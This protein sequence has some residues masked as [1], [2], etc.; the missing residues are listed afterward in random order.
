MWLI[1]KIGLK[2]KAHIWDGSDTVCRMAS[3]GLLKIEKFELRDERL[4]HEICQRCDPFVRSIISPWETLPNGDRVRTLT[5]SEGL[6][7]K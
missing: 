3:T 5:S 2:A 7:L 6:D 1:R 4:H